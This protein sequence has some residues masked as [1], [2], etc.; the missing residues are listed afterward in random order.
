MNELIALAKQNNWSYKIDETEYTFSFYLGH[1]ETENGEGHTYDDYEVAYFNVSKVNSKLSELH[2]LPSFQGKGIAGAM[3]EAA[4]E[5][6]IDTLIAEAY[7]KGLSLDQLVK[8]YEKHGF[9]EYAAS[10]IS[11][12]MRLA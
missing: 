12:A 3:V 5:L 4:K 1:K 2:V 7:K 8:F 6:G 11:V 10:D 9:E